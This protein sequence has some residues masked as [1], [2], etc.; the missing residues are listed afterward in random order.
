[1]STS[2]DQYTMPVQTHVLLEGLRDHR[3]EL[4]V[5]LQILERQRLLFESDLPA[6]KRYLRR[7]LA[8]TLIKF[9]EV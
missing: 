9:E 7:E 5:S 2:L 4:R 8:L 3:E 1:M 6:I